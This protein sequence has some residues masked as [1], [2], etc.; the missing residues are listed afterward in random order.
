MYKALENFFSLRLPIKEELKKDFRK[1]I[2]NIQ[3][4][5]NFVSKEI[6][7]QNALSL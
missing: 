7:R 5:N 2:G 6:H 3:K 4:A 1:L